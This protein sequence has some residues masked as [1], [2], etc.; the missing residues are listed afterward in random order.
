MKIL[1]IFKKELQS[2]FYSPV[3]YIVFSAFLLV[4]G[5]LF[6]VVMASSM[7]ASIE[8]ILFNA[9][10]ILLLA[11]PVL[12]MR[13]I[14][15]E[16]KTNTIEL[17][18]TS[19][20][21]PAEVVIGKFLAC[22]TVYLVLTVLTF[23]YPYIIS[24]YSNNL[25]WGPIYSGYIG[26]LLLG[27]AFISLGLFASS[28]TENQV[29]SAMISFSGLLLF[30]IIGWL[31]FALDNPLGEIISRLSLFDRYSEFLK[32]V[33]DSGNIVYFV[34]FIIIWLFMATRVLESDRWR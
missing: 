19:P 26:F 32:G 13:L 27:A 1:A 23:Q 6:Y 28:L 12:T 34:S 7:M 29:I 25:D 20:V 10:F 5:Y 22:F 33:V 2:Y 4:V 24:M 14:S 31:K 30:W 8:P 18:L 3:A 17:L 11:S 21:S 15:E 16:R 9:G